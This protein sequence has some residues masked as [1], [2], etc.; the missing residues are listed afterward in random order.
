MEASEEDTGREGA[1]Q[2]MQ[3]SMAGRAQGGS[4]GLRTVVQTWTLEGNPEGAPYLELCSPR[5]HGCE[6]GSLDG[7]L[8]I[9][10]TLSLDF[11]STRL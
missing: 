8:A 4:E 1:R 7:P 11:S 6:Q 10:V 3:E 2:G 5:M 9:L